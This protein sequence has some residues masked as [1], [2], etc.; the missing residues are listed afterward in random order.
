MLALAISGHS[1]R[2]PEMDQRDIKISH[3][4]HL[5]HLEA[6]PLVLWRKSINFLNDDDIAPIPS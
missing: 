1:D 3:G 2:Y 5:T 4:T 6:M